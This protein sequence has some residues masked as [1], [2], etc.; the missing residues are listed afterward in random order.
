MSTGATTSPDEGIMCWKRGL[1]LPRVQ[2][3]GDFNR[4]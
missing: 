2:G 3:K 4:P 1:V